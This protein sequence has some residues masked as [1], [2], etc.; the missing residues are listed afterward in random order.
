LTNVVLLIVLNKKETND[1][2]SFREKDKEEMPMMAE[3]DI[4]EFKYT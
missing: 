4:Q 2:T 1:A 3:R